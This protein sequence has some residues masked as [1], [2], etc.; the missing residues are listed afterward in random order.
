VAIAHRPAV[1]EHL[2]AGSPPFPQEALLVDERL[3]EPFVE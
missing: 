1:L 2:D 3:G